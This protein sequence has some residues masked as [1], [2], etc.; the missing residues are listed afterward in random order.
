[1][2]QRAW[3]F[4]STFVMLTAVGIVACSSADEPEG[5]DEG[6]GGS[7]G[8]GG[9]VTGGST[10]S[11]GTASGGS[12]TGGT[13]SGGSSSGGSSSGGT[14]G[15]GG[16]GPNPDPECKGISTGKACTLADKQCPGMACGIADSGRRDCTCSST[17][18]CTPCDYTNSPFKDRPTDILE[19]PSN[20]GDEVTCTTLNSV[21]GPLGTEYCACYQDATDG[22]I[23]DCDKP[24]SSWM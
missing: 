22:L 9:G 20:A 16:D 19:C 23:W 8:S 7:S 2:M 14:S 18:D 12:S 6:T 3:T 11:G 4:V 5:G 13:S 17:W 10:A 1:M 15:T 24:P 21:C